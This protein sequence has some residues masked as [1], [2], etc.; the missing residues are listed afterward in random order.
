MS[1]SA[2]SRLKNRDEERFFFGAYIGSETRRM[3]FKKGGGE[4]NLLFTVAHLKTFNLS[5]I[6]PFLLIYHVAI[7]IKMMDHFKMV[8]V[9]VSKIIIITAVLQKLQ[10]FNRTL[11]THTHTH[12]SLQKDPKPCARVFYM[13]VALNIVYFVN[14]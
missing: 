11:K 4:G 12:T 3:E 6:F 2:V 9:T 7:W 8:L 1:E 5:I 10:L 13:S 14:N